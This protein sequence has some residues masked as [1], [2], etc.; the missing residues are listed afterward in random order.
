V[1]ADEHEWEARRRAEV[2]EQSGKPDAEMA[3]SSIAMLDTAAA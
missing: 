2:F 1:D 3:D